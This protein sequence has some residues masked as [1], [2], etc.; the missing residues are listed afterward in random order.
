MFQSSLLPARQ[1]APSKAAP[2]HS[3]L[4][5]AACCLC[6]AQDKHTHQLC[7][8]HRHTRPAAAGAGGPSGGGVAAALVNMLLDNGIPAPGSDMCSICFNGVRSAAA[9]CISYAWCGRGAAHACLLSPT[10]VLEIGSRA[11]HQAR[12]TP[13]R[14]RVTLIAR[15]A[16]ARAHQAAPRAALPHTSRS[17]AAGGGGPPGV[18][19]VGKEG[20]NL[21]RD[22]CRSWEAGDYLLSQAYAG[23]HS[24]SKAAADGICCALTPSANKALLRLLSGPPHP[25]QH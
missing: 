18:W 12:A 4:L 5:P 23:V 10:P 25:T 17:I 9:G 24:P 20:V 16:V 22:G 1:H 15:K 8:D 19:W 13:A 11:T 14:Y 7:L 6:S 2:G 3:C 21:N